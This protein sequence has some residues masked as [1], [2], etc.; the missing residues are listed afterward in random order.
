MRALFILIKRLIVDDAVYFGIALIGSAT[1]ILITLL[2]VFSD[3]P[4]YMPFNKITHLI[5][6]PVYVGIGFCVLG[7]I[8]S[9]SDRTKG[10]SALLLVLPVRRG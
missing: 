9:H 8:Q 10:I 5:W 6:V 2:L 4:L 3:E 7:T 1:L